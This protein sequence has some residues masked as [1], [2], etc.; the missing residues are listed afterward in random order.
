MFGH[1][2]I[3]A[4]IVRSAAGYV[5]NYFSKTLKHNFCYHNLAHTI[6][7][8]KGVNKLCSATKIDSRLK[9]IILVAAWFHDLGYLCQ[10]E[11][12]ERVSALLAEAFLRK[13][14]IDQKDI[15][16]VKSC[17]LSTRCPQLPTT[18]ME[19]V[20]CDADLIYLGDQNFFKFST[21]L[22]REWESTLNKVYTDVEWL[23]INISFISAH[24]FHTKYCLNYLEK[25]KRKNVQWLTGQL[26]VMTNKE[27]AFQMKFST[28]HPV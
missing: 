11:D 10:I 14:N 13:R 16:L 9:T 24:R 20:L 28:S 18:L 1:M 21:Q 2:K 5:R 17:I 25:K 7:V 27:K 23:E 3:N 15:K 26:A 6:D 8:T 4:A 19:K 12:H 22:R